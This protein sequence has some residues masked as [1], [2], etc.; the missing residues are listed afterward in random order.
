MTTLVL[1]FRG[2]KVNRQGPDSRGFQRPVKEAN[3]H[4]HTHSVCGMLEQGSLF[5]RGTVERRKS[6]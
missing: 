5:V 3:V 2:S 1:G 4:T 6:Y